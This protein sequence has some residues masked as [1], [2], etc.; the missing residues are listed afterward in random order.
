MNTPADAPVLVDFEAV[1]KSLN[2]FDEIAIETAFRRPFRKMDTG[3]LMA[4][5]ILFTVY[6]RE[7][8]KDAD[9]YRR[10]MLLT[11]EELESLFAETDPV[12]DDEDAEGK[13]STPTE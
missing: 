8:T 13:A 4:R 7:G 2:G 10:A 5:A 6:R 11:I 9:A 12:D 1:A 3:S